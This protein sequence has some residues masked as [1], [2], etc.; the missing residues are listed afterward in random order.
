MTKGADE[1]GEPEEIPKRDILEFL[2]KMGAVPKEVVEAYLKDLRAQQAGFFVTREEFEKFKKNPIDDMLSQLGEGI[3]RKVEEKVAE[4]EIGKRVQ[5]AVDGLAGK[6]NKEVEKMGGRLNA[7]AERAVVGAL[8]RIEGTKYGTIE[9]AIK[10]VRK[11]RTRQRAY[12]ITLGAIVGIGLIAT[13]ATWYQSNRRTAEGA[14]GESRIARL[15]SEEAKAGNRKLG[16]GLEDYKKEMS[17]W[18]KK[19]DDSV[20]KENAARDAK[21]S[22][23]EQRV[24]GQITNKLDK[25]EWGAKAADLE[26]GIANVQTAYKQLDAL[27]KGEM[28]KDASRDEAYGKYRALV[29]SSKREIDELR[30][31]ITQL[32]TEF[33][34]RDYTNAELGR[35]R[36]EYEGVK[37]DLRQKYDGLIDVIKKMQKNYG[38]NDP[39]DAEKPQKNK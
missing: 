18:Q 14:R 22:E 1:E 25:T 7:E 31:R 19:H 32:P 8:N 11:A 30:L 20:V 28:A 10:Q 5:S 24:T 33:S 36:T 15:S 16:K 34:T 38:Q 29:E 37:K 26:K 21:N 3:G 2:R 35:M 27:I 17:E 6:I 9:E 39:E 13:A 23:L 4:H 12:M